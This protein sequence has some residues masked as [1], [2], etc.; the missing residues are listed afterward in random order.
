MQEAL[1]QEAYAALSDDGLTVTFYYETQKDTRNGVVELNNHN[2]QG[3]SIY[4]IYDFTICS[5]IVK[6]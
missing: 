5:R 6:S 3:T 1:P 2:V 4:S